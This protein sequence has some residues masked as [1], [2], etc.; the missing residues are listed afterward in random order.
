M[1]I[2]YT[3]NKPVTLSI[4]IPKDASSQ[5]N[6]VV[7]LLFCTA[8]PK[9]KKNFILQILKYCMNLF[10]VIRIN[11]TIFCKFQMLL[12]IPNSIMPDTVNNLQL[13]F[14]LPERKEYIFRCLNRNLVT[15]FFFQKL[16]FGLLLGI[17]QILDH[18]M[19]FVNFRNVCRS[20]CMD[21]LHTSSHAFYQTI[22]RFCNI[23]DQKIY[24][25]SCQYCTSQYSCQYDPVDTISQTIYG[26]F[27]DKST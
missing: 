7:W 1:N 20:K 25:E 4:L 19:Q 14:F 23:S 21:S 3:A 9:F 26:F 6:P 18:I 27:R 2:V 16:F 10:Y 5:L 8:K 12:A 15:F 22:Y 24:T 11:I 17:G 13:F